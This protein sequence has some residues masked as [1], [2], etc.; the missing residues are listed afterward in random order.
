MIID[1]KILVKISKKNIDHVRSR[2]YNV[3]L[4]DVIII[5]TEDLNIG[6]HKLINVRCDVCGNDK[7]IMFQKYVKNI[8]NGGYYACSSKCAQGKVKK[9]CI[10]KFGKDYYTH[11]D[12]YD[13]DVK[14][15]SMVKYGVELDWPNKEFGRSYF[16]HMRNIKDWYFGETDKRK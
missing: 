3:E 16:S 4:K 15:S 11:T 7:K 8:K 12:E 6:S 1:D 9:T 2:G 10:D 14:E 13:N 5:K